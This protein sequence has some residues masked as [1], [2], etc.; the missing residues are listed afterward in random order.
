[1][2]KYDNDIKFK[3]AYN[4]NPCSLVEKG[5]ILDT[6]KLFVIS[7][8]RFLKIHKLCVLFFK[9]YSKLR[10]S[11]KRARIRIWRSISYCTLMPIYS[12]EDNARRKKRRITNRIC[13]MQNSRRK[14]KKKMK[15][16]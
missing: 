13:K 16:A 3:R 15:L 11:L 2:Y 9:K 14:V 7:A 6:S 8:S 5:K 10:F 4:R 12:G 1:M